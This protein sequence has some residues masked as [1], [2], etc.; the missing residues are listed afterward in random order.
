MHFA[1]W[2]DL[3]RSDWQSVVAVAVVPALFLLSLA[4]T[5]PP[6][7]GGVLP[8]AARFVRAWAVVFAVLTILDPLA[9]GPLLRL[10]GVA[11]A[12]IATA[13]L[14]AFV[15]LGDFRVYL[16]IFT[17]MSYAGMRR[18]TR[19]A[20][21]LH[22][23]RDA[24]RLVSPRP[25]LIAALATL[26]VPIVAFTLDGWL[27]A[28]RP[29]LPAQSIWLIYELAFL[30]VAIALRV[31]VPTRVPPSVPRLANY[32]RAVLTYVIVY[33]ALWAAADVLIL[34]GIDAGWALRMIPNQLYY[35]FWVP[36]AYWLFFAR[37]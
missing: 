29:D 23:T 11:E 1:T 12:P 27:R 6:A 28:R 36:F 19:T 16:L 32:L 37:R 17:L 15:L 5:E 7:H 25:V 26:I 35:A 18:A 30:T 9:G 14:I 10:L 3:Y 20:D 31:W 24:L 2:Q 22:A 21:P 34:A 33:Y 4:V 13:V 8:A